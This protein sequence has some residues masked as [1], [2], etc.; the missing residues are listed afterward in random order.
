MPLAPIHPQDMPISIR[1]YHTFR[2][3]TWSFHLSCGCPKGLF[4]CRVPRWTFQTEILPFLH[5]CPRHLFLF[6]LLYQA[7]GTTIQPLCFFWFFIT[8]LFHPH[9]IRSQSSPF[10]VR[11]SAICFI[12]ISVMSTLDVRTSPLDRVRYSRISRFVYINLT[13]K[14]FFRPCL[15][16]K[17]SFAFCKFIVFFCGHIDPIYWSRFVRNF[18]FFLE[19]FVNQ[20]PT[21]TSHPL[22]FISYS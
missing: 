6:S 15:L 16:L 13:F 22:T 8:P 12:L 19:N 18:S 1:N 21:T 5:A 9:S 14:I 7:L 20:G 3:L 11:K 2:I 4:P 17:R 10:F